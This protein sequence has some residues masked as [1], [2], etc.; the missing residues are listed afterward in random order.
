MISLIRRI[1]NG[2]LAKSASWLS[3][4][5]FSGASRTL[6]IDAEL[7]VL[8]RREDTVAV[9]SGFSSPGGVFQLLWIAM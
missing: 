9:G 8:V 3:T 6:P 2:L 4:S 1:R 5:G 7:L